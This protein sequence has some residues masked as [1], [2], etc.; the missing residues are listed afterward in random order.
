MATLHLMVGLPCSG[1]TT[2]AN[3]L[4]INENALLLTTDVWHIKLFGHD[5]DDL[6]LHNK[7]HT[8]IERIIWDVAKRVL[9]IGGS[10]ILDFGFWDRKERDDFRNRAKNMG[11]TFKLHYMDVP[12]F[13]LYRRLEERNKNPQEGVFIIPKSYM[14]MFIPAFEIPGDDEL[15]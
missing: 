1:K 4:A 5:E 10:V 2:Y 6:D 7:R 15:V 12:Y 9:D 13:E 8:R 14:D 11:V 3:K